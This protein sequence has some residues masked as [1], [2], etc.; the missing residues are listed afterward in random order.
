M[1]QEIASENQ[2]FAEKTDLEELLSQYKDAIDKSTIVSMTNLHGRITYAND[3]F[4]RLSKYNREELVGKPHN[5]V[6]HP[7]MPK[8]AFREMWSTIKSGRIW[9]GIVENRAKDGSKYIVSTTI[10][11]IKNPDGT[12]KEYIGIRSDISELV[13]SQNKVRSLLNASSKFVPSQFLK[14][15]KSTDLASVNPGEATTLKLTVLFADIRGFT[16]IAEKLSAGDIFQSL[17]RYIAH[18]EPVITRNDGFIDKFIGDGVMALFHHSD[19]ALKAAKEMLQE[20]D[21]FNDLLLGEG[22]EKIRIGI[23]IHY[24]QVVL[25]T[26]GTETRMN[27]TVIGDT[28]NIAARMEKLTKRAGVPILFTEETLKEVDLT[29]F[30]IKKVG[31][32]TLRGRTKRTILYTLK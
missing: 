16:S 26:V 12:N 3:E 4:C 31:Q 32:S 5:I 2:D 10:I 22:S 23:G 27:T 7:D 20:L 24:G 14:E 11:P 21:K 28:V 8:E 9:K 30:K 17:N 29:K 1:E 19:N 18:M 15:L 13:L 25:G 6:R